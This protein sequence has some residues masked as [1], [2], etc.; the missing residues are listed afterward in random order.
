MNEAVRVHDVMRVRQNGQRYLFASLVAALA[1]V[2][3]D[4]EVEPASTARA[5]RTSRGAGA[6]S[7]SGSTVVATPSASASAAA[8]AE[9]DQL[10]Q[11]LW[12][13][14]REAPKACTNVKDCVIVGP[15]ACGVA[16]ATKSCVA[17]IA[18][19]FEQDIDLLSK[20]WEA[21]GCEKGLKEVKS[22]RLACRAGRC[23]VMI[24]RD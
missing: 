19:G 2:G 20:S 18:K 22:E 10:N 5:S 7:P 14:V 24:N 13:A 12:E 4:D 8:N 9:C 6:P 15:G 23:V 21:A 17:G 1:L 16:D 11:A 3:C